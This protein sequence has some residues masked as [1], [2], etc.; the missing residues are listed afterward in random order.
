[1]P[2]YTEYIYLTTKYQKMQ[3]NYE[4]ILQEKEKLFLKTQPNAMKYDSDRVDGGTPE[5][6]FD[7]YLMEKEKRNID[8][9][10]T[11]AWILLE[12]RRNLVKLKEQELKESK[13]LYDKI[14]RMHYLE[15][16]NGYRI[17]MRIHYSVSQVYK[18]LSK[19]E[20]MRQKET[21]KGV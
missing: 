19:M 6:K 11:E 1:M 9:R 13:D 17:S 5:N 15:K 10:L 2:V 12:D 8:N 16:M 3:D 18:I 7:A 20:N 21:K 4:S 14:Y